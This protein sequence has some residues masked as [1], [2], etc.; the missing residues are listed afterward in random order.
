M[1]W[2]FKTDAV[3][4]RYTRPPSPQAPRDYHPTTG[5]WPSEWLPGKRDAARSK[6]A[7]YL[8]LEVGSQ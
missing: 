4:P 7:E 1:A 3:R 5:I 2:D 8:E 6:L